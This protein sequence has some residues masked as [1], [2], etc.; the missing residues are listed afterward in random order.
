MVL[1]LTAVAHASASYPNAAGHHI[2]LRPGI[3]QLKAAPRQVAAPQIGQ[4][5]TGCLRQPGMRQTGRIGA[6]NSI[7]PIGR[8]RPVGPVHR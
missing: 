3:V 2:H 5:G 8:H 6:F 1:G 7:T 4:L